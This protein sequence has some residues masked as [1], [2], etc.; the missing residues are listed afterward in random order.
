HG[1]SKG[2]EI[3]IIMVTKDNLSNSMT[4][5]QYRELIDRL[6]KEGRTSGNEQTEKLVNFTRLN[7][8]R[9]RRWEKTFH[10]DPETVRS[11][12]GLPGEEVWLIITET[13]CGDAAQNIPVIEKLASA[14]NN[15]QTRYVLRDENLE[16]MDAFLT[17]GARSI[18]KLIRIDATTQE[19][20][21]TWGPRPKVIHDKVIDWKYNQKLD[22]E[23]YHEL[24]HSWYFQDK[25]NEIQK[26]FR[27]F[28]Q[29]TASASC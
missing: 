22:T 2:T 10:P 18:P 23:T 20:I 21:G 26:E 7:L 28:S 16:L 17:N 24:L 11:I 15:I 8:S 9:I 12:E 1:S 29:Q 19:V 14:A 25:G 5:Q 4:Y 13:W 3:T 6:V 27:T